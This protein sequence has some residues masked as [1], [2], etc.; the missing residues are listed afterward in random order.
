MQNLY[1][2][3]FIVFEGI[4]GSGKN[5]QTRLLLDHF[6]RENRDVVTYDFPQYSA[7]SAGLLEEY[8]NGKYGSADEVGPYRASIFYACDRYDASFKIRE[9]LDQGKILVCDR[10]L[11]SNIGH[12]GGK[13]QDKAEREKFIKWLYNLEYGI[14]GIPK[15]DIIFILKTSPEF[16][17]KLSPQITDKEKKKKRKAYLGDK[18][19]D[20]HED[21]LTHLANSLNSYLEAAKEFPNDFRIIECIE[22]KKLLSPEI[23]HQKVWKEIKKNIM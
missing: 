3:K 14:F 18:K 10:Y 8:L 20:I 4:D 23:I 6:R 5:T 7:K 22:N 19:R 15:P 9:W 12:Q 17:R 1:K 13:I 21:D 2:G 11:A 16:S